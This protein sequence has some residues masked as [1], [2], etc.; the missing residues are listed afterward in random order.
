MNLAQRRKRSERQL[1]AKASLRNQ[2]AGAS[3]PE[4]AERR[5]LRRVL[6]AR[7][8]SG[9]SRLALPAQQEKIS[10]Y[11]R[12][13]VSKAQKAYRGRGRMDGKKAAYNLKKMAKTKSIGS[14]GEVAASIRLKMSAEGRRHICRA[15]EVAHI[16]NARRNV[17]LC[18]TAAVPIINGGKLD[19]GNGSVSV[20]ARAS[21]SPSPAPSLALAALRCGTCLCAHAACTRYHLGAQNMAGKK[22]EN[23]LYLAAYENIAKEGWLSS[24]Q[25][26]SRERK[27]SAFS[28]RRTEKWKIMP[29]RC[30]LRT[31]SALRTSFASAD[32]SRSFCLQ[33][34]YAR[35]PALLTLC[36]A[37]AERK[38]SF[39]SFSRLSAHYKCVHLPG[40]KHMNCMRENMPRIRVVGSGA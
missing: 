4:A 30:P 21:L 39:F 7:R 29:L 12:A 14:I 18:G 10:I 20:G 6:A 27:T 19:D 2:R 26:R 11:W 5:I 35:L 31:P 34:E 37:C 9:A 13:G 3:R 16:S 8:K 25:K 40:S 22:S 38:R 28:E 15:S 32:I 36:K 33:R 1:S 23:F 24:R 17:I